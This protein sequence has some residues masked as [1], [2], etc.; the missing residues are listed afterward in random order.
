M[1]RPS[2][3]PVAWGRA[4]TRSP[5]RNGS[6]HTPSAPIGAW[7]TRALNVSM[8]SASN[9]RIAPVALVRFMVQI[10]GSQPP[11]EEQNVATDGCGLTTGSAA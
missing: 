4:G 8:S 1:V 11:L 5:L 6:M 9:S 10:S 7:T 2:R 3:L